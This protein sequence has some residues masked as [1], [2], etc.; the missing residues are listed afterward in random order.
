VAYR[1]RY[2][3]PFQE[4]AEVPRFIPAIRLQIDNSGSGQY[5]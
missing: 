3:L 5:P 1:I 4:G 2:R